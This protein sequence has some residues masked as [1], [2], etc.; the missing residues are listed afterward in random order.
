M[1]TRWYSLDAN[2]CT[3]DHEQVDLEQAYAVIDQY[4]ARLRPHYDSGEEALSATMF[5]FIRD[6]GSYIQICL[7][8]PDTINVEYDFSL[9]KNQFLRFLGRQRR[10]DE[11]LSSREQVRG[12]TKLFFTHSREAFR[13]LLRNKKADPSEGGA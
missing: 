6:D 8:A 2:L 4:F 1:T 7:H 13:D 5:G 11:Q 9:V 10:C 12:R 3:V